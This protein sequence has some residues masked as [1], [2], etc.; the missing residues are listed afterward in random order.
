MDIIK[1]CPF[2]GSEPHVFEDS[3][4]CGFFV[5]CFEYECPAD[6]FQIRGRTRGEVIAK[7]NT[8]KGAELEYDNDTNFV[9]LTNRK[10]HAEVAEENGKLGEAFGYH[11]MVIDAAHAI[12]RDAA[13]HMERLSQKIVA[14]SA[15][16][17]R[18]EFEPK[19]EISNG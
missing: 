14:E 13:A 7:W 18:K 5:C 2:C 11:R 16:M 17:V 19:Q 9:K 10:V 6:D 1:R 4:G 15:A 8:R 12:A 3:E